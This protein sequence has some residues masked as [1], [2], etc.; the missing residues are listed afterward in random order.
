MKY[1]WQSKSFGWKGNYE[2]E[3]CTESVPEICSN[4]ATLC[5]ACGVGS[6]GLRRGHKAPVGDELDVRARHVLGQR[7]SSRFDAD[8]DSRNAELYSLRV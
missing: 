5:C 8:G 1:K 4:L 3:L 6:G 7:G 2:T